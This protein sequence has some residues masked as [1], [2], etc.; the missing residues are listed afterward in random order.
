MQH[1][2]LLT[3]THAGHTQPYALG[4]HILTGLHVT[5]FLVLFLPGP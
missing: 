2:C 5:S 1:W 3:S 4:L